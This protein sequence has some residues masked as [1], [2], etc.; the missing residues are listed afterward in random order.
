VPL[1]HADVATGAACRRIEALHASR[2]SR[3]DLSRPPLYCT[4]RRG[5]KNSPSLCTTFR[6]LLSNQCCSLSVMFINPSFWNGRPRGFK[7]LVNFRVSSSVTLSSASG[8][9]LERCCE[10]HEDNQ[11]PSYTLCAILPCVHPSLLCC[12]FDCLRAAIWLCK[13]APPVTCQSR[14]ADCS[15]LRRRRHFDDISPM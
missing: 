3:V 4:V 15:K 9:M 5:I 6:P 2:A 7:K 8:S 14:L 11:T 12:N 10:R 13:A 1:L